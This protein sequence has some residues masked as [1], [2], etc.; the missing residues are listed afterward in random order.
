MENDLASE[1]REWEKSEYA[2]DSFELFLLYKKVD[3]LFD[4]FSSEDPSDWEM[5]AQV[6]QA[7]DLMELGRQVKARLHYEAKTFRRS[8]TQDPHFTFSMIDRINAVAVPDGCKSLSDIIQL[9][10]GRKATESPMSERTQ[11]LEKDFVGLVG[12]YSLKRLQSHF[13]QLKVDFPFD[14]L[15]ILEGLFVAF[16]S[17]KAIL[18][19]WGS[20]E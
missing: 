17:D 10:L 13:D 1:K 8:L 15:Y 5:Y 11:K 7:K 19:G 12:P 16:A 2:K 9:F 20:N 18:I 6:Y 14:D 4:D 3:K